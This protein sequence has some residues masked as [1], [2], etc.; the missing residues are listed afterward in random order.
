MHLAF[1]S[2]KT[3]NPITPLTRLWRD[4]R[5]ELRVVA[6]CEWKCRPL[7]DDYRRILSIWKLN[8]FGMYSVGDAN[9]LVGC[10]DPVY[11]SPAS[12]IEGSTGWAKKVN[13]K[14]S[15]P[16]HNFVKCWPILKIFH[17]YNHQT[18]C[19]ATFIKYPATPQTRRYTTLWNVYVRK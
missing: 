15:R 7:H 12:G 5:V 1:G 10:R 4:R 8:M 18:I 14:C 3:Y 9:A 19:N 13:P 17:C 11:N 6:R 2:K 16:T